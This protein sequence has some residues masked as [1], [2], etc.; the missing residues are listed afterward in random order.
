M[1]TPTRL[2]FKEHALGVYIVND[3]SEAPPAGMA[4]HHGLPGTLDLL[5]VDMV[6]AYANAATYGSQ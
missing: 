5:V 3:F 2:V 4:P 6:I 1:R